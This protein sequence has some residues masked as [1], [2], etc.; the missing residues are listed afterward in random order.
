MSTE[1]IVAGTRFNCDGGDRGLFKCRTN[2]E[3]D[4]SSWRDAWQEAKSYG[5]V[6]YRN[7]DGEWE[8]YCPSCKKDLG[9]D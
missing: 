8:H 2:Y 4:H 3:S 9:D 7:N 1:K 5:W 6:T